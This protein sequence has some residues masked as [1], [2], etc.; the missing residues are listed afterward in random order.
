MLFGQKHIDPWK[1]VCDP[2]NIYAAYIEVASGKRYHKDFQ[3]FTLHLE[4]NLISICNDL[5]WRTYEPGPAVSFIVYEPKKRLITRPQLRDRIVHHALM[6]VVRNVFFHEFHRDS[7]ACVDGKGTLKA[8]MEVSHK[9]RQAINAYGWRFGVFHLD[10]KNYF[11]SIDHAVVKELIRRLFVDDPGIIWLFDKIIDAVGQGLPI[12]FLTSQFEANLVGTTLDRC[13]DG[14]GVRYHVRYMDDIIGF[15]PTEQDAKE[16]IAL[17]DEYCAER[18]MLRLNEKKSKASTFR[19]KETFCGYVCAPH[20]LEPKHMTVKRA[21]KRIRK[22]IRQTMDG[23]LDPAN[24][25]QSAQSLNAYMSH[26]WKKTN[27]VAEQGIAIASPVVHLVPPR[28]DGSRWI[29]RWK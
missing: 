25:K 12:G 18:L 16:V 19:G 29:S 8:C 17:V 6:R 22:K 28:A 4:E 9:E 10:L 27:N 13:L 5:A 3:H 7:Y 1:R 20:H 15:V 21:E 2:D 23:G 24:L 26:T 14:I 11:G